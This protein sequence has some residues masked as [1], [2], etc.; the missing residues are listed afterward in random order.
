MKKNW[1]QSLG[2]LYRSELFY[3]CLGKMSGKEK[4]MTDI[5]LTTL[6]IFGIILKLRISWNNYTLFGEKEPKELVFQGNSGKYIFMR[7]PTR[8]R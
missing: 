1:V 7:H 2:S 5:C 6:D 8:N 3:N 4:N